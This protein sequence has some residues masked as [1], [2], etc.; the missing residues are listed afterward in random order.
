MHDEE[1]SS[2]YR[3]FV[4]ILV[5]FLRWQGV[6]LRDAA[7]VA[8]ETM[9]QAYRRWTTIDHPAAWARRVAARMWARRVAEAVE[10]PVGDVPERPALLT[11]DDVTAWEQRH[12][13][14]RVL[15]RLPARQRQVLAWRLDGYSP[16]EIAA[17]LKMT[18]EAVRS[19]LLKARRALAAY[20][21]ETGDQR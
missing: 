16:V 19:S 7:D 10:D 14:L 18:A 5:A 1:F 6:P 13:V 21:R 3:S 15:D 8:Q 11:I 20:L 17:E 9:V 2:F 4:P 12:E